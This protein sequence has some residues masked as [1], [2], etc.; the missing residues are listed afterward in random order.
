VSRLHGTACQ[1]KCSSFAT[2]LSRLDACKNRK[3]VRWCRTQASSHNSQGVVDS[4]VN[5]ASVTIQ[6]RSTLLSNGPGQRWLFAALLLQNP[7]QRQKTASSVRRVMLDS[8]E[9]T[10]GVGD[11][12]L[13]AD[14]QKRFSSNRFYLTEAECCMHLL[15]ITFSMHFICLLLR[16]TR[17]Q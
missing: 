15:N 8:C 16:A 13:R 17:L 9:V 11:T 2:K 6:E 3:V 4:R 14:A 7:S 10:Q 1:S 12:T 5:E